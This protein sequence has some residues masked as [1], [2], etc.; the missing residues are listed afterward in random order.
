MAGRRFTV[1]IMRFDNGAFVS[2]S[3]GSHRLGATVASICSGPSTVTTTVIPSK[4]DPLFLKLISE[5]TS[6]TLHGIVIVSGFF[7]SE[8]D[9]DAVKEIMQAVVEMLS[10]D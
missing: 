9:R 4:S 7:A 1:R 2:V 8:P 5:R 6:A 10:D 3:E